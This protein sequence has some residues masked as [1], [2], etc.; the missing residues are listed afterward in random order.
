V[1]GRKWSIRETTKRKSKKMDTED[2]KRKMNEAPDTKEE[3]KEATK[4]TG[5]FEGEFLRVEDEGGLGQW[6]L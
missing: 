1:P 3:G 4:R 6:K 2:P 5:N